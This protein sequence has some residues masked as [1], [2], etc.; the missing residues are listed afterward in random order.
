M[1]RSC[2]PPSPCGRLSRPRT[3][4]RTP[5]RPAPI[6]RHRALPGCHQQPGARG[7]LPT[8]TMIRL[9]GSAAGSTPTAHPA[10]TRSLPP[11]TTPGHISRAW[12][13]P[14]SIRAASLLSTAR[15]RQVWGRLNSVR[16]F[17]H[18]IALALPFGLACT[19]AGVWQYRPAVTLSGRLTSGARSRASAVPSFSRPL[20]QPGAGIPA[21]T[22]E[23]F[24]VLHLLSLGASWRTINYYGRFY[25]SRLVRLLKRINDYLIRWAASKYKRLRRHPAKARQFLAAVYRREPRTVRALAPRRAPRRLDDGSRM[26]REVHVRFWERRGAKLPPATHPA[27]LRGTGVNEQPSDRDQWPRS[28]TGRVG[29]PASQSRRGCRPR[30]AQICSARKVRLTLAIA[31][32]V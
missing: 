12:S 7:A 32:A 5:P 17:Y 18:Q 24:D 8:F 26:S 6:S 23:M 22:D 21:G 20:H 4:T 1:L 28:T 19:H 15:V 10:G 27:L 9:T 30:R 25:R 13:E 16:G 14:P 31:F 11:A 29:C 3:T 2:C